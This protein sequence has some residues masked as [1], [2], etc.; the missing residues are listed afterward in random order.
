MR[1][2]I[3]VSLVQFRPW[4]PLPYCDLTN[5]W[6][7]DPPLLSVQDTRLHAP[8]RQNRNTNVTHLFVRW[9]Q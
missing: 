3:A 9:R 8:V 2:K 4:A 6:Y 5:S 1:L 7:A